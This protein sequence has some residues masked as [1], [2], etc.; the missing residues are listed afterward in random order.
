MRASVAIVL[1]ALPLAA[2]SPGGYPV[3]PEAEAPPPPPFDAFQAGMRLRV[4]MPAEVAVHQIGWAPV[5]SQ[6]TTCGILA[7]DA[8]TC[9]AL[10]FGAYD[11][12]R[13]LVY[14]TPTDRGYSVVTTWMVHKR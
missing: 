9:E 4:G 10:T 3:V 1:V 14:L 13:L 12:N 6:V 2:C 7:G 5:S 8:N 11:N